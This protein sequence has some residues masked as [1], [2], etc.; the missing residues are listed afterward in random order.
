MGCLA[1]LT[2]AGEDLADDEID[3]KGPVIIA[4]IGLFGQVVNRLLMLA[5]FRAVVLDSNLEAIE[6]MR[7]FA[8]QG[9]HPS[10]TAMG[11]A[12][13]PGDWPER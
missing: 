9:L 4:G 12:I 13:R 8:A 7:R 10:S 3:A 11:I 6:T 1:R 5:G 2:D